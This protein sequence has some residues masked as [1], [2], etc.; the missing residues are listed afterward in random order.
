MSRL[1]DSNRNNGSSVGRTSGKQYSPQAYW[2]IPDRCTNG[3]DHHVNAELV[4]VV[5][6]NDLESDVF[7]LCPISIALRESELVYAVKEKK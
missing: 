6:R 4:E 2:V 1:G 5:G 3:P 7:V